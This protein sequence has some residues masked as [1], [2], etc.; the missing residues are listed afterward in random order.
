MIFHPDSNLPGCMMPDGGECCAGHT[1]VVEDWHKQ[2]VEIERLRLNH[3]DVAET[4]RRTNERLKVA[5]KA[6]QDIAAM[7]PKGIRADDLG[8][9]ARIASEGI[10]S[11]VGQQQDPK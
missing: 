7:D 6:L 10:Q 4:K 5:I 2:H 3:K 11:V 9:A 8:R 1:A